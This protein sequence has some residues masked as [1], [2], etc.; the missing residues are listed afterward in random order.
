M[1]IKYGDVV[2]E[3]P[4]HANEWEPP[5]RAAVYVIAIPDKT[6]T[7]K[8]YRP[9]YFGES[10]NLSDRGFWRSHHR[11]RCF[12]GEAGSESNL[13]VGIHRMPDSTE[14]QRRKVEQTLVEKYK[15]KCNM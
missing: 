5:C 15:P 7:P 11:Y 6:W 10:G 4:Y 1:T 9:V 12:I 14:D 13:Y 3:G 8:G 2:F